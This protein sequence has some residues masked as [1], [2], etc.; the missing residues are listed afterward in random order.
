[1]PV[2]DTIK[3]WVVYVGILA[4]AVIVAFGGIRKALKD[5]K[6]DLPA[7]PGGP[8]VTPAVERIVGGAILETTTILMWSESN[9]AVVD[10]LEAATAKLE[11]ICNSINY[12]TE[13]GRNVEDEIKELRHQIERLRDKLP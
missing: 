12:A 5:L 7:N 13:T 9:R 4:T 11:S 10:A 2:I 3:S 8:A 6:G 1:M